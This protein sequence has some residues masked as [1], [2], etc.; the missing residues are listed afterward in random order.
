MAD[1]RRI[2]SIKYN[3]KKGEFNIRYCNTVNGEFSRTFANK[4]NAAETDFITCVKR[5]ENDLFIIWAR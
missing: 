2:V 1:S 5:H 3:I 4:L